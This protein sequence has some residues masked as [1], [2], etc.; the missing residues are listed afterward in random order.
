MTRMGTVT[1]RP[2]IC[3]GAAQKWYTNARPAHGSS[4]P[5]RPYDST[6]SGTYETFM[7]PT[8]QASPGN[9]ISSCVHPPGEG[10]TR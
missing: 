1:R 5:A 8:D 7:A 4:V 9:S 2:L 10:T 6:R 3:V